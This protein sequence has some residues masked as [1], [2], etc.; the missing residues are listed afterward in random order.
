MKR[1]WKSLNIGCGVCRAVKAVFIMEKLDIR[2]LFGLCLLAISLHGAFAQEIHVSPTGGNVYPFDSLATA[3][4]NIH[5][6]V[7]GAPEGAIVRIHPGTYRLTNSL[8]VSTALSLIGVNGAA[9]TILDGNNEVRCIDSSH[10][11]TLIEGL[12]IQ[13]GYA[14]NHFGESRDNGDGGGIRL[15]AGGVVRACAVLNNRAMYQGGGIQI[16]DSGL[17]DSCVIVSNAIHTDQSGDGG[18]I[19]LGTEVEMRNCLVAYN[20]TIRDGGGVFSFG[21][22]PRIRNSTIA[23]N[24]AGEA[25]GGIFLFVGGTVENSIVYHNNAPLGGN[26]FHRRGGN[27]LMSN[28]CTFPMPIG[29]GNIPD[30]PRFA[31]PNNGDFRLRADSLCIDGGRTNEWTGA[32][33]DLAGLPRLVG[34]QPDMGAYE[35]QSTGLFV[36][37]Q[38]SPRWGTAPM[39]PTYVAS[40]HNANPNS[41]FF[42]W[43]FDNDGHMDVSGWGLA[44][45][46]IKYDIEGIYD[47]ALTVSNASTSYRMVFSNMVSASPAELYVSQ[48]GRHVPPFNDWATAATNIQ[49]ALDLAMDGATVWLDDG[50]FQIPETLL[51]C[52]PVT[53]KSLHGKESTTLDGM[54]ERSVIQLWHPQARLE[55][56]RIAHGSGIWGGGIS[57]LGGGQIANSSIVSNTASQGGGIYALGTTC[58]TNCDIAFNDERGIQIQGGEIAN[59]QIAQNAGGG[60]RISGTLVRSCSIHDNQAYIGGGIY[61]SYGD[62]II[63]RCTVV[64]NVARGGRGGGLYMSYGGGWITNTLIAQNESAV[65][66]GIAAELSRFSAIHCTI[67]H[68]TA[69]TGAG[70]YHYMTTPSYTN[71]IISHNI[72]E[73]TATDNGTLTTAPLQKYVFTEPGLDVVFQDVPRGNFRLRWD[74]P[75]INAGTNLPDSLDTIDLDGKPR[76]LDGTADRGVYEQFPPTQDSDSDGLPDEWECTY[77]GGTTNA[78]PDDIEGHPSYANRDHFIA[79]TNPHEPDSFLKFDDVVVNETNNAGHVLLKWASYPGRTYSVFRCDDLST[80]VFLPVAENLPATLPVNSYADTN[81]AG[82]G[83]WI[84][85]LGIRLDP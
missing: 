25:G 83:P 72:G 39:L 55:G 2:P 21:N 64:S 41:L 1:F 6:A 82:T 45:A 27:E 38:A 49:A 52:R 23:F 4:T 62:S 78:N 20:Q 5:E 15:Q 73:E 63:D 34:P 51:L 43:D 26:W 16:M 80:G 59:C 58:I 40:V 81:A 17:V 18:G 60:M 28:S 24:S 48:T 67:A 37:V 76:I 14:T 75:G 7:A 46:P 30:S 53:L 54:G 84:Y 74:S 71:T 42:A 65:G 8:V 47:A 57:A 13:R 19:S 10:P 33:T 11:D 31:D 77:F 22:N 66:G 32:A 3:S 56:V 12:T 68:N 29:P 69:P 50:V 85:R 35:F 9:A 79:G 36:S 70:V 61:N 44:V